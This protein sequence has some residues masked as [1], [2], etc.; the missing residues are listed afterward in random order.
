MERKYRNGRR[1]SPIAAMAR[2][3]RGEYVFLF[4]RPC[5]P[6]WIVSMQV[7]TVKMIAERGGIRAAIKNEVAK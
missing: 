6:G 4:G 5:N 3:M 2:A 1:L 7:N